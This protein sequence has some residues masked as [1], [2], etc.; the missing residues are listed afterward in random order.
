MKLLVK[1]NFFE[2]IEDIRDRALS[3]TFYGYEDLSFEVGWRG[4]R[5]KEFDSL[6]DS[7]LDH[8]ESMILKE[9]G[10]FFDIKNFSITTYFHISYSK[11]K[12][13]LED[14]ESMKFHSDVTE[15]AG[16][17]Y[18]NPNPVREVGTAIIG[19]ETIH[20]ENVYNR[21]VCYPGSY[22]HAPTDLFGDTI[23]NGRM[24]ITFFISQKFKGRDMVFYDSSQSG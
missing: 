7:L 23:E 14:F 11:T 21:L 4:Y 8:C 3:S 6:G 1:D 20:I 19:D 9:V 15:Y 12:E 16:I 17:L 5:T 24:V 2:N 10:E 13:T 22:I 18:L